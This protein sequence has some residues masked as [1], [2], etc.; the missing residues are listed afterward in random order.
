MAQERLEELR[1]QGY[2]VEKVVVDVDALLEWCGK[3]GLRM[4]NARARSMYVTEQ[5]E[6]KGENATEKKTAPKNR[7]SHMD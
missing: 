1:S 3:K 2:A 6:A 7:L 4:V 5:L